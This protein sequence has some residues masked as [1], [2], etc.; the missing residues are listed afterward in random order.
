MPDIERHFLESALTAIN[1]AWHDKHGPSCKWH[2]IDHLERKWVIFLKGKDVYTA[3][4]DIWNEG[5]PTAAADGYICDINLLKPEHEAVWYVFDDIQY[6]HFAWA[7]GQ[8][9]KG[10]GL[11]CEISGCDFWSD[12]DDY[13]ISAE[14]IKEFKGCRF[15]MLD[16]Y[17]V[18]SIIISYEELYYY[19]DLAVKWH[20]KNY[21]SAHEY[22]NQLNNFLADYRKRFLKSESPEVIL[23]RVSR[24]GQPA[25][26]Q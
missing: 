13:A 2:G 11:S 16:D 23:A 18:P 5:K 24:P 3:N 15:E 22:V 7:L 19:M 17:N 14:H 8:L 9:A 26:K 1:N 20:I 25:D 4:P 10:V 21:S 6:G 12:L